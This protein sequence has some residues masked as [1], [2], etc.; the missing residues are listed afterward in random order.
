VLRSRRGHSEIFPLLQRDGHVAVFPD[1]IVERAETEFF[2][3]PEARVGSSL[4]L[5]LFGADQI[6]NCISSKS[7]QENRDG[8]GN[9]VEF[10]QLLPR[11][12]E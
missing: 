7:E 10:R 8:G 2:A 9:H 1:K 11:A 3:L 6:F 12:C 4:L 5:R